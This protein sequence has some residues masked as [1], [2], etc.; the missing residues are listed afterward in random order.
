MS[1]V[2]LVVHPTCFS[3]YRLL[4]TLSEK[5][6]LNRLRI[7]VADKPG[8]GFEKKAWSVPWL[9]VNGE[10]AAAD[11]LEPWEVEAV[12][13][14]RGLQPP[15][16][17][18]ESFMTSVMHSSYASSLV[19]L[20]GSLEPVLDKGFA[21]AVYRAPLTHVDVDKALE[22]VRE[23]AGELYDEWV[24]KLRRTLAVAFTRELY[25]F[26]NR[27]LTADSLVQASR[28]EVI[29]AWLLAKASIGRVGLPPNPLG[30]GAVNA[31]EIS[32]FIS[33]G[34]K[35]IL[36][37]VENEAEAL[38]NDKEYWLMISRLKSGSW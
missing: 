1:T 25:W 35:G 11:P 30:A 22:K 17:L 21:K 15:G 20:W 38:F 33:K 14:G 5:G 26:S 36:N 28:P 16:D 32:S 13:E 18:A 27:K 3:S 6:L 8:V 19:V 2:E 23:K 24:D 10:P 4:K 12:L 7:L 29:G 37:K 9:L 31:G 34:A